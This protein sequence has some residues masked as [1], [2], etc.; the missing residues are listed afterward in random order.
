M[1]VRGCVDLLFGDVCATIKVAT[2]RLPGSIFPE[3]DPKLAELQG[4]ILLLN[5]GSRGSLRV[6]SPSATAEDYQ[7]VDLGTATNG[8]RTIQVTAFGRSKVYKGVTAIAGDFGEGDDSFTLVNGSVPVTISGGGDSDTLITNGTGSVTFNGNGGADMLVGGSGADILNGGSGNDYLEGRG[9]VDQLDGGADDDIFVAQIADVFGESPQ[10]GEGVDTYE[11]IGTTGADGFGVSVVGNALSMTYAGPAGTGAVN[12]TA[13][14]KVVLQANQGGDTVTVSGN[15]GAADLRELTLGLTELTSGN[16][17]DT[18]VLNLTVGDDVAG[19][20]GG[21]AA[22]VF[23]LARVAGGDTLEYPTPPGGAVPLT[24][25][26]WQGGSSLL[27]LVGSGAGDTDLFTLNGLAGA[28]VFNLRGLSANTVVDAG[29]GNDLIAIGSLANG[30]NNAGGVVDG[31]D[32]ALTVRGGSGTDTVTVDDSGDGSGDTDGHLTGTLLSGLGLPSTGLVYSQLEVLTITLGTGADTFDVDSTSSGT[33]TTVNGNLG[34]DT[35]NV[36]DDNGQTTVHGNGGDDT[37]NVA[38]THGATTV[39]GDAGNDTVNVTDSFG[40]LTVNGDDGTDTVTVT[41]THATTTVNGGTGARHH[42]PRRRARRDGDQRWRRRRH[43]HHSRHARR[44]HRPR[45]QRRRHHPD[46]GAARA[47]GGLRRPRQRHRS[48]SAALRRACGGVARPDRA[49]TSSSAAAPA[50]TPSRSTTP[51]TR[52]GDIGYVTDGRV[53][54]P[55]HDD[56]R[57]AT[58]PPSPPGRS[59]WP[60]PAGGSF[61]LTVGGHDHGAIAFD[62]KAKVVQ[63][64]I[65]AALGGSARHR[66]PLAGD[67]RPRDHVPDPLG[68]LL[69]R[70]TPGSERRRFRSGGRIRHARASRSQ[71]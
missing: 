71:R 55:R 42:H 21:T 56:R 5:V 44:P 65:N 9:G 29:D 12:L 2:I 22:Q 50:P 31:V 58:P 48:S 41:D 57:P 45:R 18:I 38:T 67:P 39:H 3:N 37:V 13:F 69:H 64:A 59:R 32:G 47:D 24:T 51:A 34:N 53:A 8:T 15:L 25:V 7:I 35:I 6:V 63:D 54:G 62:A 17:V 36:N 40:D 1:K 27:R 30:L 49:P 68:R 11:I 23:S 20:T 4:G 46:P 10:A 70:R 61:P 14:E 66:H 26:S 60:T 28:D 52:T 19:L 16:E 33:A 43:D